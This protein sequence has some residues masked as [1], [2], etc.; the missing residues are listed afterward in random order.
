MS[1]AHLREE[2][3]IL[4]DAGLREQPQENY[5][6]VEISLKGITKISGVAKGLCIAANL[7]F[8]EKVNKILRSSAYKQN[9]C[10][11]HRNYTWVMESLLKFL[12]LSII[13]F[14]RDWFIIS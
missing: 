5:S 3:N 10:R 9:I 14:L 6:I 7:R 8:N 2:G 4:S 13:T 1:R 11:L 12:H